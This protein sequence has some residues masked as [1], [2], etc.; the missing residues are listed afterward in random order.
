MK[1]PELITELNHQ[2]GHAD[3]SDQRYPE[4]GTARS[5]NAEFVLCL[6]EDLFDV[7]G[8]EKGE[9]ASISTF[10]TEEEACEYILSALSRTKQGT[11]V[12]S[13]LET[14]RSKEV[15]DAINKSLKEKFGL[16]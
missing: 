6:H 10:A 9:W 3:V 7:G 8:V 13:A 14:R 4:L 2:F 12:S 5:E 1:F 15:S 11:I 16:T